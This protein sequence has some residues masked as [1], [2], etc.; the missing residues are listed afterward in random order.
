MQQARIKQPAH[1]HRNA[2][3]T[4]HITH[5]VSTEGLD[6]REQRHLR[7]DAVEVLNVQVDLGFMGD[8]QQM[9]DRIGRASKGHDHRDGVFQGLPRDDVARGNAEAE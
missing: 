5:H 6:V 3:H 9:Q 1:H 8:R 4:I 7:A 2:A